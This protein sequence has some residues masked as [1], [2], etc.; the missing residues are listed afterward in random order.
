MNI[1]TNAK[2]LQ[3]Q[4]VKWRRDLHS[5]PEIGLELKHTT[6][7]ICEVLE[8]LGIKYTKIAQ[9][10]GI[11]ALIRG[12]NN[13]KV[14]ALR[15]DMDAVNI[16]EKTGLSY[17]S[18]NSNMHAC[19]H[20]AHIAMLLG[21]AK[22]L[23][24]VRDSLKCSVKLIFQ[25]DE[26][27]S[28]GARL[29]IENGVLENPKVN[30]ILGTHIGQLSKEIECGHVGVRIGE[31]M[32]SNDKFKITINGKECHGAMPDTGI[33]SILIASHIVL[34]LQSIISRELNPIN[35]TVITVGKFISG[36]QY[37]VVSGSAEIEGTVRAYNSE[38]RN[39]VLKRIG[40][41]SKLISESMRAS[42]NYQ[43]V[44]GSPVV[45]NDKEFTLKFVKSAEKIIG[46]N[47]IKF[48]QNPVMAGEDIGCY[49]NKVPGT[50]FFLGGFNKDKGIT[51]PHHNSKFDI[52][53]DVLWIGSALLAQSALDYCNN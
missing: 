1:S 2:S 50:F 17:A 3:N 28:K 45:K 51:Y 18:T 43:V 52:D 16:K 37:N 35:P 41:I 26:E 44:L 49:L 13:E 25:P 22:I 47:K 21:A 27:G 32:A 30:A 29:M 19:G 33:D 39:F 4:I 31:L 11:V 7:Y 40:E 36:N 6:K 8:D 34:G 42:C 12:N 9:N 23:N 10:S 24:E 15:A 38:D 20:D 48:I 53:E 14:I 46:K 5:M